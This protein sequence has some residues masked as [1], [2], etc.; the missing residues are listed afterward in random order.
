MT[1]GLLMLAFSA[2]FLLLGFGVQPLRRAEINV[3]LAFGLIL[4]FSVGIIVPNWQISNDFYINIGGFVLP[5][6]LFVGLLV[7]VVKKR[8][9]LSSS[10]LMLC[11]GAL[12]LGMFFLLPSNNE[13]F[14]AF[15]S[16]IVGVVVGSVAFLIGKE[17]L[18]VLYAVFGGIVVA[19]IVYSIVMTVAI[20]KG[21][22]IMGSSF[23]YNSLFV[24]TMFSLALCEINFRAKNAE[25]QKNRLAGMTEAGEDGE[26]SEDET[27]SFDDLF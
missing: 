25:L 22:W 26:K 11:C 19:E 7:L 5:L 18:S 12:T 8:A 20:Y 24:A 17:P 10:A 14:T 1:M 27:E 23:I 4:G 2:I 6:I 13:W 3:I 15:S 21:V 9:L 16:V